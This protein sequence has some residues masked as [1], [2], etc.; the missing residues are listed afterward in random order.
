[1]TSVRHL[2]TFAAIDFETAD[3]L[4]D[5][6]CAVGVVR[7]EQGRLTDR[8]YRLIR[9]PRKRFEFTHVHGL[10]WKDVRGSPT[11]GGIWPELREFIE[12]ADFLVAHNAS[13]DKG[14]LHRCCEAA[15]VEPPGQ[16]FRCT[17]QLARAR[18]DLRSAGLAAVCEHLAIP[19]DHHQALSDA[20]ACARIAV[21]VGVTRDHRSF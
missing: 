16:E 9:P 21:R 10:T 17:M 15:R 14:V 18:W 7:V 3:R 2:P 4:R 8:Y 6:A 20:E 5:S 19:L 12:G 13:F 11:F 1:M